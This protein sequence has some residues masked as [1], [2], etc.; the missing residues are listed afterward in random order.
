MTKTALK[1]SNIF[2]KKTLLG[3]RRFATRGQFLQFLFYKMRLFDLFSNTVFCNLFYFSNPVYFDFFQGVYLCP[4][5]CLPI[6]ENRSGYLWHALRKSD[7]LLHKSPNHRHNYQVKLHTVAKSNFLFK[8][9]ILMESL[10]TLKLNF[11]GKNERN[12]RP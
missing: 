12:L 9:S 7:W 11:Q 8:N 6:G 1:N 5:Y 10:P 3:P 4:L 2:T